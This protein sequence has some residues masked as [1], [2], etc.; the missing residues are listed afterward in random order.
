MELTTQRAMG[1]VGAANGCHDHEVELTFEEKDIERVLWVNSGCH[2]GDEISGGECGSWC[3]TWSETIFK[4][5]SG[6]Y[7]KASESSDTSGHG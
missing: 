3:D 1:I 6:K 7:V 5:K 4:L 2:C